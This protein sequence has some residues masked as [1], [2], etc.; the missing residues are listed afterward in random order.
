[1]RTRPISFPEPTCLLVSTKTRSLG[2]DQKAR[3]LWGRDWNSSTHEKS[4]RED[5][6]SARVGEKSALVDEKSARV[7]EKLMRSGREWSE[8]VGLTKALFYHQVLYAD[9]FDV[10]HA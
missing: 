2:A 9:R 8:R 1:M 3:G 4:A 7:D 10:F 6:K 5:K